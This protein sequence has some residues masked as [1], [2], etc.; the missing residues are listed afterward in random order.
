ME[1]DNSL[2]RSLSSRSEFNSF[3]KLKNAICHCVS[4]NDWLRRKKM[5]LIIFQTAFEFN[6]LII[7]ISCAVADCRCNHLSFSIDAEHSAH[8]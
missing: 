6:L 1:N 5:N 3:A 8:N 2:S 4:I 7:V